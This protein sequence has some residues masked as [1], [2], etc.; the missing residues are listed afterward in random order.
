MVQD[1]EHKSLTH[2][3]FVLSSTLFPGSLL[4]LLTIDLSFFEGYSQQIFNEQKPFSMCLTIWSIGYLLG[5]ERRLEDMFSFNQDY[6]QPVLSWAPCLAT[7]SRM[8]NRLLVLHKASMQGL[9]SLQVV[10][11]PLSSIFCC[12]RMHDAHMRKLFLIVTD[13][14]WWPEWWA[15]Q[16]QQTHLCSI[17]RK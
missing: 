10:C 12:L 7:I 3:N 11:L 17:L 15:H 9:Y 4:S 16:H 1:K 14:N 5:Y 6:W 13:L 2:N 8:W